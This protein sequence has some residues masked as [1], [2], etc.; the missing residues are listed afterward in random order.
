VD[1]AQREGSYVEFRQREVRQWG[2]R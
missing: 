2:S 1:A